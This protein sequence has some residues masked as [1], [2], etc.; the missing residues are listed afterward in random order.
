MMRRCVDD[1]WQLLAR[2]IRVARLEDTRSGSVCLLSAAPVQR[3]LVRRTSVSKTPKGSM[4]ALPKAF[5]VSPVETLH[6]VEFHTYH[7]ISC[8][9]SQTSLTPPAS[10]MQILRFAAH[11]QPLPGSTGSVTGMNTLS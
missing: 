10:S 11:T 7:M 9:Y 5:K 2:N 6:S 3:T 4:N 8:E 1:V